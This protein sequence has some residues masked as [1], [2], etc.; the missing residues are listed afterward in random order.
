MLYPLQEQQRLLLGKGTLTLWDWQCSAPSGRKHRGQFWRDLS[1]K[2]LCVLTPQWQ[3]L[4]QETLLRQH[5]K[6]KQ[7]QYSPGL[8]NSG[9]NT[10]ASRLHLC[11]GGNAALLF[12]LPPVSISST[13]KSQ[14]PVAHS[15][16]SHLLQQIILDSV[17]NNLFLCASKSHMLLKYLLC[18][19][20]Q[21]N[22]PGKQGAE[23]VHP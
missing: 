4:A 19:Q 18:K 9:G 5:Q 16:H 20:V 8:N 23:Q 11:V 7:I 15:W 2:R 21:N 1:S 12:P 6:I 13:H 17:S 14:P 3:I 22:F 10:G